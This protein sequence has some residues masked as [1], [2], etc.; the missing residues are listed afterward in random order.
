MPPHRHSA[1]KL[2]PHLERV[3]DLPRSS[4]RM[5]RGGAR[6]LF[7]KQG[8]L[9]GACGPYCVFMAM[10]GYGL[11]RRSEINWSTSV[12]RR[13]RLGKLMSAID[14]HG[15]FFRDGTDIND[16]KAII[17][18]SFGNLLTLQPLTSTGS[19]LDQAIIDEVEA[20]HFVC[21]WM[22]GRALSHWVLVVGLEAR[23]EQPRA[24]LALDPDGR[25]PSLA[26]WNAVIDLHHSGVG[27]HRHLFRPDGRRVRFE[28]AVGLRLAARK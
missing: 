22:R 5:A 14:Q 11:I 7:L 27:N 23:D 6:D 24:L 15:Q 21:L 25:E 12:D 2:S 26:C 1:I 16:L 4:H 28:A 18:G 17:D 19:R 20:G 9:D 8:S 13:T 3:A 10:L